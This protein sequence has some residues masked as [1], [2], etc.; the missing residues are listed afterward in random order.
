MKYTEVSTYP[1]QSVNLFDRVFQYQFP[2]YITIDG[3]TAQGLIER[4]LFYVQL[5]KSLNV[6]FE[7]KNETPVAMQTKYSHS[8]A[9]V[10]FSKIKNQIFAR[11][12]MF[13]CAMKMEKW[14][15]D[16]VLIKWQN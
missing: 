3:S 14:K 13:L 4:F 12:A 1:E 6:T 16:A 8:Y 15:G 7:M 5:Y 11:F 9:A 10:L 2:I